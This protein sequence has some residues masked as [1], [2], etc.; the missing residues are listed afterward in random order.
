V[1]KKLLIL[2][3]LL[4]S[5]FAVK[6]QH[7]SDYIR[8]MFNGLLLNPSYAGSHEA[9]DITA[10]YRKQW[11]GIGGAPVTMSF[12]AHTA[13]KNKRLNTGLVI[14]N[15]RFG[16]FE[17]TRA[18]AIYAYR[19]RFQKGQ[20]AFGLQFGVESYSYNWN[21]IRVKDENDPNFSDMPQR[22][23]FPA[24]GAG[25]YYHSEKFYIGFAAPSMLRMQTGGDI[26]MILN[27]GAVISLSDRWHLK[28]ALI[29]KYLRNSP[30]SINVSAT[31]Y[32]M[33]KFGIGTGY[34]YLNAVSAFFDI[35]VNDQ[36]RFGYGYAWPNAL[37]RTFSS[38]SHEL[39]LNYLFRYKISAVSPRYF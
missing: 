25:V 32:Y 8:Y 19:F 7:S 26:E 3:I 24:G 12:G 2:V 37:M 38:G 16:L 6:A 14:E 36:L 35:G 34:T 23:I 27:S 31:L 5:Y 21:M 28:P 10:L 18:L 22:N 1:S 13:L 15:D 4:S 17:S 30:P 11:I 29:S 39:M 33:D 9:M 20:L